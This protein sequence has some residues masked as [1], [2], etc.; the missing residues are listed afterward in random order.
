MEQ[1]VEPTLEPS[2][3]LMEV[4]T[5]TLRH[6]VGDLLQTVYATVAILQ[7]RLP[8][9]LALEKR[10]LGDL[11]V[12]AETCKNELDAAHDL[13]CPLSLSLE[14]FDLSELCTSLAEAYSR[15]YPSLAVRAEAGMAVAARGDTRR[16]S[17][18]GNLLLTA[19][20]QTAQKEVV[21][22]AAAAGGKAEWV[23]DDDGPGA[24]TEQLGW[25]DMPFTTTHQALFGL[26]LALGRRVAEAAGGSIE[27]ANRP[28]GGFRVRFLL[29]PAGRDTPR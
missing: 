24:G 4:L 12:R 27:A 15:R 5:R 6:E 22:R 14:P 11:R 29:P 28:E 9:T 13:V 8:A 23:I 1:T 26:G 7:E 19:A 10:L 18:V 25:L 3:Q 17:H 21:L 16:L 2:R 20:C